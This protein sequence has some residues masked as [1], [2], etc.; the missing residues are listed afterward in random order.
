MRR[1]KRREDGSAAVEFAWVAWP[2]LALV[3][4]ILETAIVF[5]ASQSLETAVAD[6]GRLIM[7]GQA[8]TQ[9]FDKAAF[10]N[11]VCSRIL[12]FFDCQAGLFVD[13]K[14]YPSFPAIDFSLPKDAAGNFQDNTVYQPGTAGDIVVVR[15]FYQWPTYVAKLQNLSTKYRLLS[16]TLAFRNEPFTAPPP[17]PPPGP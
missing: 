2:F 16:A 9:G 14:T 15:L 3:F 13:V 12:L 10:K 6:S 5:F 17:S 1:L 8:Q 7:T 4:A 11:S